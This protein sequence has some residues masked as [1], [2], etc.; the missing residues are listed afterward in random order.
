MKVR[1]IDQLLDRI[2]SERVWRIR[3][4]AA[5]RSQC[6]SKSVSVDA[7]RAVRRAFLPIAYAHWEGFVKKSSHYY[8]EFV[9]MQRLKLSELN[10]PFVSLYL[11]KEH[12]ADL[13]SS[14]SFALEGVCQTI[15]NRSEDRVR[16]HYKDVISTKSNL[17]SDVLRHI[18]RSLGLNYSDFQPKELFIDAGLLA[19]RNHIAHGE[20]QDIDGDELDSVKEEVIWLIDCFR[21][22]VENAAI[23][24][25]YKLM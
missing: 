11:V 6:F 19:K 18:C 13:L 17:N 9:S 4:I 10:W 7:Q 22:K 25:E 5:L 1:T 24:S 12:Q 15:A 16:L 20:A 14:G 2:S 3:E 23:N 8:L 21:N